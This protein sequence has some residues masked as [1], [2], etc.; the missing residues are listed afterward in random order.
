MEPLAERVTAPWFISS[1]STR[2]GSSVPLSEKSW[3]PRDPWRTAVSTSSSRI[4]RRVSLASWKTGAQIGNLPNQLL[5]ALGCQAHGD[6]GMGSSR[7]RMPVQDLRNV[8]GA[9]DVVIFQSGSPRSERSFHD[10]MRLLTKSWAGLKTPGRSAWVEPNRGLFISGGGEHGAFGA[11][12]LNGWSESFSF[13]FSMSSGLRNYA[14]S[15]LLRFGSSPVGLTGCVQ[16]PRTTTITSKMGANE[17]SR[18]ATLVSRAN[19]DC[20]STATSVFVLVIGG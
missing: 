3:S 16:R 18:F 9:A 8:F 2:Y 11:G 1:I 4:A 15:T 10:E 5:V 19:R 17:A 12:L 6:W 20:L 14:P 7:P 13:S